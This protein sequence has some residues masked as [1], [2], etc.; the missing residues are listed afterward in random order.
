MFGVPD[1]ELKVMFVGGPN[2]RKDYH[3]EEGEVSLPLQLLTWS[4]TVLHAQG[5]HATTD[6]GEGTDEISRY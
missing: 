3:I 6:N 5:R 2:Q 1:G 4:G